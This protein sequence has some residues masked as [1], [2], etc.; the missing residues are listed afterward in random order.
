VFCSTEPKPPRLEKREI[1]RRLF[2]VLARM[3]ARGTAI[4]YIS[5]GSTSG[6]LGAMLHNRVGHG[7]V[8]P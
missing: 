8:A 2:A 3:K 5:H 7:R 4:I 6:G 1:E